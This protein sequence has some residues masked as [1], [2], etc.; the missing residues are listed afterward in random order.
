MT[1]IYNIRAM[2]PRRRKLRNDAPPAEIILWRYLKGKQM[3]GYK[4]RRQYSVGRYVI[5]FYCPQLKLAI[6]VD[7]PSHYLSEQAR[8]YDHKRQRFIESFGI[9][10]IRVTNIEIYR[11]IEG[12]REFIMYTINT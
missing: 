9:T 2:T 5:D 8:I 11:T 4:F 3:E 1:T 6:E 12:V 7:G 10:L